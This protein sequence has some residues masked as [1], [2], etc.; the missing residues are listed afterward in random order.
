MEDTP[1]SAATVRRCTMAN[2]FFYDYY[3]DLLTYLGERKQRTE[4]F[5]ARAKDSKVS[6]E[7]S[8]KQ[9]KVFCGKE[10]AYLRKRRTR[11]SVSNFHIITQVGQGGY[12]QVYLA[13]N[14][15]SKE[16]CA[17]KKMSKR[18][19]HKLGEVQHILTER[20]ILTRTSTEWL[21][22][23]LYAF[24]DTDHVYLAMEYVPGGDMRTLLNNFG[25]LREPHARFYLGE[26]FM[27]V[28]EL[29]RLG[30]IHRDLKPENFLIDG[31]GHVKLT[32]FGL[33]RGQISKEC[34][35]ALRLK[36]E[37]VK[38]APVPDSM[39]SMRRKSM[40]K[41]FRQ[42]EM[43]AFS[44]VGSPD[45]MAPEVLT[46]SEN[47]YGLAV[48]YWSLGCIL[49]ECLAGY[50]PFTASKTDDVWVNVYHWK[51][52]LERPLYVGEDL[53]FN[54]S[55]EAWGLITNLIT[56]AENRYAS[57]NQYKNHP[58]FSKPGALPG[59]KSTA[60]Q[61]P[62][63]FD[64]L[65]TE[66]GPSPP[67]I[68]SLSDEADTRYFDDFESEK[69]MAMYKEVID[70]KNRLEDEVARK[71][72]EETKGKGKGED[73]GDDAAPS[74]GSRTM[75]AAFVGFTFKHKDNSPKLMVGNQDG[76]YTATAHQLKP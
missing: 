72:A 69:A 15:D 2:I 13:R 61:H 62:F 11:T 4:A 16:L 51:K 47:G 55:D 65:R 43:R 66:D 54:L 39:T 20:D 56:D 64:S 41:S 73:G 9:W 53:E 25:V 30:F 60:P 8:E 37:L 45:Y 58:F 28:A 59:G 68:P 12:G 3:F 52:V 32:D 17:L 36:L 38:G 33:S 57:P 44:L 29:H 14:K 24:Q 6:S 23:L 40:Y 18:L 26:M 22:K 19:L 1:V 71:E 34:I 48:D 35:E 75:R 42:E 76:G 7:E 63:H 46:N 5:K 50:P 67:F 10:R 70:R 21:V 27:G 74:K 49:F 31:G